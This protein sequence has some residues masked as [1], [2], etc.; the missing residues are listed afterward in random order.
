VTTF[1]LSDDGSKADWLFVDFQKKEKA[2]PPSEDNAAK[3]AT[4]PGTTLE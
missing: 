3:R 1:R 2:E 4:V